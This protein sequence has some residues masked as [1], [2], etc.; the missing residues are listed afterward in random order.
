MAFSLGVLPQWWEDSRKWEDFGDAPGNTHLGT[1]P[2]LMI[3][4]NINLPLLLSWW[5]ISSSKPSSALFTSS[6]CF[7]CMSLKSPELT[8]C[9]LD[10][11]GGTL[12]E[13][14]CELL[15]GGN[16][17][18]ALFLIPLLGLVTGFLDLELIFGSLKPSTS[19]V[20]PILALKAAQVYWHRLEDAFFCPKLAQR[21]IWR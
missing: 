13:A 4:G 9:R 21:F 1:F 5:L 7:L 11:W 15:I 10:G 16:G 8:D 14:R 2:L 18:K 12:S 17:C 6:F 3:C 20:S 19:S